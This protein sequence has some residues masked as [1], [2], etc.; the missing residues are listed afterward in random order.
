MKLV[1]D[2]NVFISS[3][4][5]GGNPRKVMMR[6][7]DGKDTLFVSDEIL[8]EV[9][10]VMAR[11]KFGVNHRQVTHFID[12]IEEVAYGVNLMGMIQGVCRD[13][14]DD[15]ILECAVLGKVDFII[16]GDNDLLS[17]K[18]FQGIPILTASE[19]INKMEV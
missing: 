1:L 6:I 5:W 15:K 12:S 11:P 7:I 19:Y 16:S 3:F 4:F 10:S 2:T 8:Q 17:L 14:D 9:F 13:S 18:E